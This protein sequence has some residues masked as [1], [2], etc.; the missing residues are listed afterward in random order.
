V[1]TVASIVALVAVVVAVVLLGLAST[2]RTMF[3]PQSDDDSPDHDD[4]TDP[5]YFPHDGPAS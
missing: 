3:P 2:A 1:L 4:L 5:D